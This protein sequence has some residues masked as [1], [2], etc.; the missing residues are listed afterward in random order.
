LNIYQQGEWKDFGFNFIVNDIDR[1]GEKK[2]AFGLRN[3]EQI[4]ENSKHF[5][6]IVKNYSNYSG[7]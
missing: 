5:A 4:W 3:L 6:V 7:S 1:K 2:I